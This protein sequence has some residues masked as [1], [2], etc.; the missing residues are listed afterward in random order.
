MCV[1]VLRL[2]LADGRFTLASG[3]D[4][5]ERSAPQAIACPRLIRRGSAVALFSPAKIAGSRLRAHDH[6]LRPRVIIY[7]EGA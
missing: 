6:G 4:Q 1:E 5:A 7:F 2:A 3:H